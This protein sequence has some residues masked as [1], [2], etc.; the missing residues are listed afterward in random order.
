M[1]IQKKPG[2]KK[3]VT[4]GTQTLFRVTYRTQINLIRIADTKANM[5]LGINAMII[6]VLIG[7]ISSSLLFSESKVIENVELVIPVVTVMLTAVFSSVFAI[8]AVQPRLILSKKG[9]LSTNQE[10]RSLLFFENIYGLSLNEY[11]ETM[12]QLIDSKTDVYENMII[13]IFN[14]ATVL[15]QKYAKL[16]TSYVIFLV[17]FITSISLF[18]IMWLAF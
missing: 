13:D 17:G 2:E 5:I 12:K 7:I 1:E 8:R 18:L 3:Q 15:H 9:N 14:Q 6:S 10:K 11:L 16:R 4:A